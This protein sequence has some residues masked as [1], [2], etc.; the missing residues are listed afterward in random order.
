M[1][2]PDHLDVL[3]TTGLI[4][5]AQ[6]EPEVEYLFRHM[7]VQDAAYESLLKQDRR[8]LHRAVA[9]VLEE[10]YPERIDALAA[11]L[12]HHYA[13]AEDHTRACLL[14]RRAG[15]AAF[16]QFANREAANHYQAAL[17][18]AD[19]ADSETL[20]HLYTR[21]G[22]TLELL[23]AYPEAAETYVQMEQVGQMRGDASLRL[24]AMMAYAL[25]HCTPST[26]FDVDRGLAAAENALLLAREIGDRAA[27]AR[28]LWI[29]SMGH[30]L[31]GDSLRGIDL[32]NQA[33]EIARELD[34]TELTVFIYSDLIN[35]YASNL[36][37][38]ESMEAA[39]Q[40][41]PLWRSIGNWPMLAFALNART[42]WDLIKGNFAQAQTATQE[43]TELTA[44]ID[45][46]E[47]LGFATAQLAEAVGMQGHVGEAIRI[48]I[49]GIARSEEL[50]SSHTSAMGRVKLALLYSHIGACEQ[51]RKMIDDLV[52]QTAENHLLPVQ[53]LMKMVLFT[54]RATLLCGSTEGVKAILKMFEQSAG[55][56]AGNDSISF[57]FTGFMLA[58]MKAASG[59]HASALDLLEQHHA[60][61]IETGA[62]G[63]LPEENL[64]R[65][66]LLRE[67]GRDDEAYD[68]LIEARDVA[69]STG[70]RLI[71]WRILSEL[72]DLE[73]VQGNDDQ[74]AH[75]QRKARG[76]VQFIADGLGDPQ[77]RAGF[78]AQPEVRALIRGGSAA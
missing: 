23:I 45:N 31:D 46:G 2:L 26:V 13:L 58:A 53:I 16:T 52:E 19:D 71:Q 29:T 25:I 6:L 68:V 75:Y 62:S 67:L 43:S 65:S 22:R 74:A 63:Y 49:D 59:D 40:A 35:M 14:Y 76:I 56:P 69:A 37:I 27:E 21:R 4:R 28:T 61:I 34:L 55:Q 10:S 11:V 8:K 24:Q 72:A 41:I 64:A 5:L 47:G 77:L 15:D 51:A 48:G 33:L 66:R 20:R 3:D 42:T 39:N 17:A 78:L 12:A 32:A 57:F 9:A 44:A 54:A 38:E 7:M 30:Y 18:F 1:S 50:G 36:Q 73:A 60:R 70:A